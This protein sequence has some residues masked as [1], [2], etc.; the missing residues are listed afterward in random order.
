LLKATKAKVWH[1]MAPA[2]SFFARAKGMARAER[3]SWGR[4][5]RSSRRL[6]GWE[7]GE[8]VRWRRVL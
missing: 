5:T 8:E 6:D 3:R 4:K 2:R 7:A 1:S